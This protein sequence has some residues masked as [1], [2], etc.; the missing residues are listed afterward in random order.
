MKN[1][2]NKILDLRKELKEYE[3][4][5]TKAI[6]IYNFINSNLSISDY[7]KNY[8]LDS[9]NNNLRQ[10]GINL[11]NSDVKN[12]IN[13]KVHIY[14]LKPVIKVIKES[15]KK[16]NEIFDSRVKSSIFEFSKVPAPKQQQMM[17]NFR[18][19][20]FDTNTSFYWIKQK[21]LNDLNTLSENLNKE[22]EEI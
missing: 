9:I 5:T 10:I 22:F 1:N 15:I 6:F 4:K 11:N 20:S 19:N 13:N 12:L 18:N 17:K 7:N 16:S 14:A 3:Y 8:L 21:R 2:N